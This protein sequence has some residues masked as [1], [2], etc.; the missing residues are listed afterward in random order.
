MD[1]RFQ[2]DADLDARPYPTL[3]TSLVSYPVT[4]LDGRALHVLGKV[5][6]PADL[7][8]PAP[9][10]LILH[11]SAGMDSR[12]QLHALDLN[13]AGYVTLEIDMWGARGLSGGA[14]GR[15]RAA[16]ENLPDAYGAFAL[17][18]D[19]PSVDAGKI[20]VMGFSWGAVVTMLSATKKY[21]GQYVSPG[22]RFAGHVAFYPACWIYNKLPGYELRDLAGGPLLMLTGERDRY[23]NDGGASCRALAASLEP[24]D[25]ALVRAQV[26]AGAEHGFNMLEAAYTYRDPFLNQGRGGEGLSAPHPQARLAARRAVVEFFAKVFE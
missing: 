7:S 20:G 11:G 8:G 4:A 5:Q 18:A 14:E 19:H 26:F 3:R 23:D 13:R 17:L 25:R 1:S 10:V 12:G 9:A 16:W 6:V 24:A 22:E 2:E 21:N 15:P